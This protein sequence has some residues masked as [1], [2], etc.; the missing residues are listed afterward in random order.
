MT[1]FLG[2]VATGGLFARFKAYIIGGMGI[3]LLAV[4]L[5]G[6]R[7]NSLREVYLDRLK[8][9]TVVLREA[10]MK[11]DSSKNPEAGVRL[12]VSQRATYLAQRNEARGLLATQ[13]NSI[14]QMERE[15]AA[16]VQ[17]AEANRRRLDGII[18]ERNIWIE[19]ARAAETRTERLT[20][21][22]EIAECEEAMNALYQA[23]F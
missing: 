22:Q 17:Q 15:T 9:I 23:G 8:T 21:E 18:R 16:A 4:S 3:A 2:N 5:W 11:V 20:A 10:G 19:R 12:A 14:R 1:G 6:I 13:S 7:A